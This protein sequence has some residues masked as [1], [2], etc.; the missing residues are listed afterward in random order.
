MVFR[1][2]GSLFRT[3]KREPHLDRVSIL[4]QSALYNA[5]LC[6]S[7]REPS[8]AIAC[9]P[10]ADLASATLPAVECII[11]ASITAFA[12]MT[13]R[14]QHPSI[15]AERPGMRVR[16]SH[17]DIH[18]AHILVM[19]K[20]ILHDG[21]QYLILL[22]LA[23][24]VIEQGGTPTLEPF[25]YTPGFAVGHDLG[26]EASNIQLPLFPG[27]EVEELLEARI[28][29]R[30]TPRR[31]QHAISGKGPRSCFKDLRKPGK[32]AATRQIRS[33]E[34]MRAATRRRAASSLFPA[35]ACHCYTSCF[36]AAMDT[37]PRVWGIRR[38]KN[39][40]STRGKHSQLQQSFSTG[41][42][43]SNLF[44]DSRTASTSIPEAWLKV[45]IKVVTTLLVWSSESSI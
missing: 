15:S 12:V 10:S 13:N 38:W 7:Q 19:T 34:T 14:S 5:I 37:F 31:A 30:D 24:P 20:D 18:L 43:T 45:D 39:L 35:R 16:I 23:C 2:S 40:R 4:G 11:V 26:F 41:T 25:V 1:L 3:T 9:K 8:A 22:L 21:R 36:A 27:F 32:R 28:G 17:H 44:G 6:T 29:A 33:W 42:L